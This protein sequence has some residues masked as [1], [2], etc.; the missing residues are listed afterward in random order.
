MFYGIKQTN[1]YSKAAIGRIYG[2]DFKTKAE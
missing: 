2:E 1:Y